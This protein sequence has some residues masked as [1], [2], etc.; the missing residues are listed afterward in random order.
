MTA[1]GS[2]PLFL[3]PSEGGYVLP[4]TINPLRNSL[5][6]P[7]L[8]VCAETSVAFA[9]ALET[10]LAGRV[11]LAQCVTNSHLMAD[12]ANLIALRSQMPPDD[13]TPVKAVFMRVRHMRVLPFRHAEKLVMLISSVWFPWVFYVLMLGLSLSVGFGSETWFVG[14][15]FASLV[16]YIPALLTVDFRM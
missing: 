8:P 15:S 11:D 6:T 13:A 5:H 3:P 4:V 14:F 12:L 10:A 9:S 7:A 1:M 16:W 2:I